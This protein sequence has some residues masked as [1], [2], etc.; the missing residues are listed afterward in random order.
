MY[1]VSD[2][3]NNVYRVSGKFSG[4]MAKL[5]A[6]KWAGTTGKVTRLLS[7]KIYQNIAL[8]SKLPK[9]YL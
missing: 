3:R 1:I 5:S 7:D 8:H 4:P 9:R 2:L 6:M